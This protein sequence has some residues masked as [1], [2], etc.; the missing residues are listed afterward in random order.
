MV[1]GRRWSVEQ[2]AAMRREDGAAGWGLATW[3]VGFNSEQKRIDEE[4]LRD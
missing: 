3:A 1:N 2:R 4:Q